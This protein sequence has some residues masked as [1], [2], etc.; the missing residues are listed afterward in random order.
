MA[1]NKKITFEDS[2]KR[3][4]EIVGILNDD[5]TTLEESIKLYE[6]GIKNYRKCEEELN[7]AK[8]KIEELS[9]E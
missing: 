5:K 2:F 4:E 3:L 6:E 1:G 8:Q 9:R 7:Q